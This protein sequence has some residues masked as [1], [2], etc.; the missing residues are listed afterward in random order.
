MKFIN[1]TSSPLVKGL[2]VWTLILFAIVSFAVLSSPLV[3]CF[4]SVAGS[5]HCPERGGSAK[6]TERDVVQAALDTFMTDNNLTEVTPSTSGV[7]G[8]KI[9]SMGAQFHATLRLQPYMRETASTFCYRWQSD[10]QIDFQYDVNADG[11]CA[12]NAKQLFP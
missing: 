10:G 5:F 1:P 3:V 12:I 6:A 4:V 11:N 2:L 9:N 8:E 7:G